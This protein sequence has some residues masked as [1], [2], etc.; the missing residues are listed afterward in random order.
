MKIPILIIVVII[1]VN[2][3][4]SEKNSNE[5]DVVSSMTLAYDNC[6]IESIMVI[7]NQPQIDD[8]EEC[9][10]AVI[11]QYIAND[12]KGTILRKWDILVN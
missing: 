3:C 2:V 4:C 11:S 1:V 6:Y 5:I 8:Y 9:A 12:F 10:K 7:V